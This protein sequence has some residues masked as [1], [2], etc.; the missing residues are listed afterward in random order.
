M[1]Q[2]DSTSGVTPYELATL[3][4]RIDPERCA[5]DSTPIGEFSVFL[6]SRPCFARFDL[7]VEASLRLKAHRSQ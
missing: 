6:P 5:S 7:R 3:A 2:S 4:S 1:E